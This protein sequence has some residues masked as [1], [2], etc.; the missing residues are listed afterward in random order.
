[1]KCAHGATVGA[2]DQD[3]LFYLR[4]RGVPYEKARAL[5]TY[6]FAREVMDLIPLRRFVPTSTHWLPAGS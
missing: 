6:A 1:V 3:A 2:L 4:S 5:L